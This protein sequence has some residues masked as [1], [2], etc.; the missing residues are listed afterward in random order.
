MPG[1][2]TYRN[3]GRFHHRERRDGITDE[4]KVPGSVDDVDLVV[5]PFDRDDRRVDAYDSFDLFGIVVTDGVPSSTVPLRL[6]APLKRAWIQLVW[7]YRHRCDLQ[8]LRC[9]A[10]PQCTFQVLSP[11]ARHHNQGNTK[12]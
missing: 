8:A 12:M 9:V 6:M 1:S 5:L 3:C 7:F 10:C 11:P 4:I 2:R